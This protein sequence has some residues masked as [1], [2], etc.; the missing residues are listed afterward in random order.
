MNADSFRS[1]TTWLAAIFVS[2][3]FVTA[4]TSPIGVF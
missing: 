3:I 2:A 4:A 1:A